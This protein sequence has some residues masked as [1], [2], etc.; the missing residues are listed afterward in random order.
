MPVDQIIQTFAAKEAEFR[1]ERDNFTYTQTFICQTLD[2][3]NR[4]DGE[5]RLTS[6]IIFDGKGKRIEVVTNAP[7]PTLE[8]VE[9]TQED[10]NDL[11]HL[12]PFVLTTEDLPKYDIKYVD[13]VALDE[14]STY[15]FDVAPKTTEKNQRYFQGRIWVDDKDFQIVKTYGQGVPENRDT[16]KKGK[17]E[18]LY[19]K[20]TTW[21]EQVDNQYWFPTYTRADDTLHFNVGDIHIREIVKYE[22][23]KRFG[24]S[25]KILYQ[26]Q[27]VQKGDQKDKDKD[28]KTPPDQKPD[29][30]KPDAPPNSQK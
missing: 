12:Y 18:N 20:F 5:Y 19:P 25:V 29:D 11:E 8:R 9:L 28:Q 2:E 26:G 21:R 13:H 27:E 23:Y 1:T 16:K 24:S 17:G 30:K 4:V 22:D 3:S 15:T 10:F 7:A 6:D 14:L